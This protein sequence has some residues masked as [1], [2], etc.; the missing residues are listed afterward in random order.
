MV[1]L[2]YFPGAGEAED[3]FRYVI[4][5]GGVSRILHVL[6]VNGKGGEALLVQARQGGG[7][8]HGAG[9][10]RSVEA[11][12]GLGRERVHVESFTAVAPAGRYGQGD[13]YVVG[14]ELVRTGGGFR[15]AADAGVRD[16]AFDGFAGGVADIG[17]NKGGGGLGHVHGLVFQRF[18]DAEA[19]A[20]NR[21]TDSYGGEYCFHI[22]RR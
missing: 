11:P 8:V 22:L 1:R 18:A 19:A 20:V 7:Q 17:F 6:A 5:D 14:L 9:A 12:D 3:F 4:R 2:N 15:G 13:P 10:L 16:H 21:G